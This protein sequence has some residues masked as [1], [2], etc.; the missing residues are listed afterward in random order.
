M[1]G[2]FQLV[3]PV[4]A[5]IAVASCSR[6]DRILRQPPS[7][8]NVLNTVQVSGLN[9]GANSISPPPSSKM[10]QESAY[11]VSEGQKLY[12]Q[13]NCSGCHAHGGGGIG[14]ALMD[15]D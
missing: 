2:H 8:S 11:A 5:A 7:A 3:I 9:P 1:H 6:E 10:Y 14:P 12:D 15:R 4:V 13:Y